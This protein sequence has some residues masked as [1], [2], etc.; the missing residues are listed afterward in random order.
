MPQDLT[1][2]QCA[3]REPSSGRSVAGWTAIGPSTTGADRISHLAGKRPIRHISTSP[4]QSRRRHNQSGE[5]L[6]DSSQA[7]QNRRATSV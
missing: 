5:P 6:V 3:F 7:A 1:D 4:R 2:D